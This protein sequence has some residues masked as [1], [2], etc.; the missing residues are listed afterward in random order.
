VIDPAPPSTLRRLAEKYWTLAHL[1]RDRALGG[2]PPEAAV[3]K[4]L[5]AEFPGCLHE[6]DTL[7]LAT[8]DARAEALARAAE[9]G[10]ADPWMAWMAGYHAL[11][12]AALRVR[13]RTLRARDPDDAR[14]EELARDASA[15]AG[16]AVDA[17]FV[18]AV[19]RP[20]GGRLAAVV[21]ARLEATAGVPAAEIK[22]ALFPHPR[23]GAGAA[24]A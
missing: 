3:F 7:P 18:R 5:A 1:R 4:A 16:V 20:P 21:F 12:R 24:G 10:P 23:R 22:R 11:F 14:A 15:H 19:A 13:S 2:R 6:L 8:I 17:A 9:G